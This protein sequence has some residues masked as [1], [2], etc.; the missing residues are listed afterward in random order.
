MLQLC[1]MQL[2]EL[3]RVLLPR[4]ECRSDLGCIASGV[5]PKTALN[6]IRKHHSIEAFMNTLNSTKHPAPE[7]FPLE[8]IRQVLTNPEVVDPKS[9]RLRSVEALRAAARRAQDEARQRLRKNHRAALHASLFD[10]F[11]KLSGCAVLR[12]VV[13]TI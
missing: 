12:R 7:H 5:G 1:S 4:F 8:E 13:L 9:I 11:C 2:S 3:N 10:R 6:G